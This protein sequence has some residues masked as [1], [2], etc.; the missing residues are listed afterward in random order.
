MLLVPSRE[1]PFGRV[2]IE[3][4]WG[5]CLLLLHRA[6]GLREI[7]VPDFCFVD[8]LQPDVWE[9]RLS[10][11][12]T[13]NEE[14]KAD[15][16]EQIKGMAATY[17]PGWDSLVGQMR[18]LMAE[19][20]DQN[21]ELDPLTRAGEYARVRK[22]IRSVGEVF[23]IYF[24]LKLRTDALDNK[25]GSWRCKLIV[26]GTDA[27]SWIIAT[28]RGESKIIRG[29]G[30]ADSTVTISAADLMDLVH[31][32]TTVDLLQ[33]IPGRLQIEGNAKVAALLVRLL[34]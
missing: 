5:G 21:Q 11:L 26:T 32:F 16:R 34:Q 3:G 7:P 20:R 4:A 25:Q 22:E 9:R 28:D 2:A 17:D 33:R 31:E 27:T 6:F 29:D 10:S 15:M 8:D 13:T 19:A 23:T 18:L 1:E 30:W 14:T 12:L 24:P